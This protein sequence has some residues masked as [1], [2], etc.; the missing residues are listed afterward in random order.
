MT[1]K[2]LAT[3]VALIRQVIASMLGGTR[4]LACA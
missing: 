4:R 3:L 2:H 1:R